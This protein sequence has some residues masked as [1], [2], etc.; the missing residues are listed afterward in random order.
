MIGKSVDHRGMFFHA[1]FDDEHSLQLIESKVCLHAK[2]GCTFKYIPK[3][4]SEMNVPL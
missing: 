1:I 3:D 2:K 4:R